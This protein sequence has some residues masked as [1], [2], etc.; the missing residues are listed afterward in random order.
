MNRSGHDP[1]RSY[2]ESTFRPVHLRV[3]KGTRFK[4]VRMHYKAIGGCLFS[5]LLL[6]VGWSRAEA[7]ALDSPGGISVQVD[8]RN[9]NYQ[10]IKKQPAWSFGGS[11]NAPLGNVMRTRGSDATGE[12]QQVAFEWRAR[13]KSMSGS[14]RIYNQNTLV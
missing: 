8:A 13:Q 4:F 2:V 7:V 3:R 14:I 11:L 1:Q 9:G 6:M 10:L 12:Y 5:A